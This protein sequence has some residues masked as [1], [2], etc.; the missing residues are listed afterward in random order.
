MKTIHVILNAHIDPIWLWPWQSGLDAALATCRSACERLEKHPDIFFSQGEA[1]VYQQIERVAPDLFERIA[2]HVKSGR[3]NLV[4]G[5]WIQPDCNLPSDFAMRHQIELGR[6]Y[7]LS[8]FNIFPTVAYNIDTFGHAACLPRLMRDAGQSCYVMMRPQ[9]HEMDL[10]ARLFR[11]RGDEN[12]PEVLTFRIAAAYTQGQQITLEHV[13]AATTNLPPG[14]EHTMCFVGVGDHGGGP[15]E[16]QIAWC[17]ENERAVDGWR[18]VFSTPD[19]FFKAIAEQFAALPLV[20]GELQH[21]A[22]GCYTVHRGVKTAVRRAE[23]LLAQA[24]IVSTDK[25]I[26]RRSEHARHV[27]AWQHVC[28]NHFHDTLGG[29]CIPSA[30]KQIADQ[31]GAAA[32]VADEEIH[33][34]LRQMLNHLVG[35]KLQRLVF[36]N[37]SDESFN[38]YAFF[39][40]WLDWRQWQPSWRLLDEQGHPVPCQMMESEATCANLT[41]I[42]T[43]LSVA[44]RQLCVLR[45]DATS[46]GTQP[47]GVG[48]ATAQDPAEIKTPLVGANISAGTLRFASHEVPLPQLQLIDDPTDT[49]SHGIDRYSEPHG[50]PTTNEGCPWHT[51]EWN[52][53]QLVDRGPLMSSLIQHGRIGRS[54]LTAEYRVYAEE[55]FAELLLRVFWTERHKVLKLTWSPGQIIQR[56]DGVM[57]GA[58]IRECAGKE[59]PLRDWTLLELKDSPRA[60]IV[61]PDVFALD[62]TPERVRLT[63]L[64]SPLLAHHDPHPAAAARVTVAD[65]GEH[66]F[67]F[68]FFVSPELSNTVLDNHALMLQRPLIFA[69]L[70]RGM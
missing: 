33:L 27:E 2:A 36:F 35:E 54:D 4:G 26:R 40:P 48:P 50:Q 17:R 8:R 43:R 28:F 29:T 51:A 63:L 58:L 39:E 11:W 52:P 32:A 16:A 44:P 30:Y 6:E 25:R 67:R 55:N 20:T 47:G 65:Q 14:I 3:W 61:C 13:N 49:W 64:R 41:R 34:G 12:G 21:H 46:G 69:D 56:T 31:L 59:R 22:I 60:G 19:Q 53:P 70:T 9:E 68:R 42:L 10:P 37:A 18:L 23:H 7:F 5:W 15:T 45:V 66:T 1:W 57:G 62:A 24:E 38:G